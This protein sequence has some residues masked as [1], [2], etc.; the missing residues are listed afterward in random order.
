MASEKLVAGAQGMRSVAAEDRRP[1]GAASSPA[2]KSMRPLRAQTPARSSATSSRSEANPRPDI[3]RLLQ[4]WSGGDPTALERLIP[5]VYDQLQSLASGLLTTERRDHT[6]RSSALVHEAYLRLVQIRQV[7]WRDRAHFFALSAR[8]MR[9]I[10]IDHARKTRSVKRGDRAKNLTL[11]AAEETL[12]ATGENTS[13]HPEL[14]DLDL[15]LDR[16][17]RRDRQQARIVELRY[18]AGL[19]REEIAMVLGISSAT[20][21]RRWRMARAWLYE[22]LRDP[23]DLPASV[24][25]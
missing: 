10:L 3:T 22:Q 13:L 20:V 23:R 21:T 6:L 19:D 9:R 11:E 4:A 16:L 18:F 2:A 15:A 17:A 25:R 8:F 24:A 5:R 14:L 12:E 7:S 1:P